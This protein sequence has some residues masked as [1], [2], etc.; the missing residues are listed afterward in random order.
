MAS[1]RI[2]G[3]PCLGLMRRVPG[4]CR[5]TGVQ[6]RCRI[7]AGHIPG[8]VFFNIDVI[9]DTSSGLPHLLPSTRVAFSSAIRKLGLGAWQHRVV[10]FDRSDCSPPPVSGGLCALSRS[11]T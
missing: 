6:W 3:E 9:A 8:A 1:P 7:R 10:Y 11:R 4:T 2:S 5:P